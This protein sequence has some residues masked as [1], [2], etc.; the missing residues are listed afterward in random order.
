[1]S[2]TPS[3]SDIRTQIDSLD[4]RILDLLTDRAKLAE[5]VAVAKRAEGG[6]NINFYRPEREAQVLGRVRE[7][8]QGPLSDD[9]VALLFREIM[10]ACLN[11]QNPLRVAFLGPEGTFTQA[12]AVK[13][14]GHGVQTA[15]VSSIGEVF[16]EVEAGTAQYGVVPI[17]NSTEGV[18][19]YTLDR[20]MNSDVSI[21]GEVDLRIHHCVLAGAAESLDQ[22]K[23]VYSH[24]QS[25][26]QCRMWLD[27]YLPHAERVAVPSNAEAAKLSKN[28]WHAA[29]IAS[30]SAGE[31]YELNVLAENIEDEPDNTTRFIIIGTEPCGASGNDKTSVVVSSTNRPGGLHDLLQPLAK[32]GV[33]MT[34]IESRPSR[35]SNWEYV[36]F[37]DMEGHADDENVKNALDDLKGASS[38]FKLLGS[39]PKAILK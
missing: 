16:R 10:S 2:D 14:F 11:L 33:S 26:A 17:E 9:Q 19:N 39:F 15:A 13:H 35:K 1:M 28:A 27:E 37:I 18:V 34:R 5:Q 23:T 32:H 7:L 12:A 24:Q 8:N 31:L 21:V 36:F 30:K 29:A 25:L 3:L 38:F 4:N 20:F 6:D 22:I